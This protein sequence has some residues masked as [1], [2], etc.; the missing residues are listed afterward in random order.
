LQLVRASN[1]QPANKHRYLKLTLR[2]SITVD[3]CAADGSH[4]AHQISQAS[5][6]QTRF[7]FH[8]RHLLDTERLIFHTDDEAA[9]HVCMQHV[10]LLYALLAT[11]GMA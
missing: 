4:A 5:H 9:Y 3:V 10:L 7:C 11:H 1:A 8:R 6:S 2:S